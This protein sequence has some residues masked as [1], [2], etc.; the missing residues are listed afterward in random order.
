MKTTNKEIDVAL[1]REALENPVGL[2]RQMGM[3]LFEFI[4]MFWDQVSEDDFKANWHI[5]Y[6]CDELE[7]IARGVGENQPKKHDLIINIPPGT[8]KTIT[9][10]IMFPVWCWTKWPWMRFICSS[11]SGTLAMESSEKCRDII[12]SDKFKLF[13]PNMGIK[14]DKDTKSNFR[15]YTKVQHRVGKTARMH[16]GGNRYSTSVGGT[17]TG[18]HGHIL[19]VDDPLNPQQAASELELE[20]ANYWIDQTLSTRKTDKKVTPTILVMQRLHQNDPSG[21]LLNK[22]KTNVKHI[23]LPGEIRNYREHL[24]PV[25]LK[26]HYVNDLLDVNRLDWDILQELETDLGQFGYAGQIGQSPT[27][28]GGGMFKVKNFLIVDNVKSQDIVQVWR[29]WDKA[30]SEGIGAF[31]AGVKMAILRNGKFVVLNVIRGQWGTDVRERNIRTMAEA[32]GKNVKIGIEQEPG[33]SG[34]ESAQSTIRNLAGW[35]IEADRPTGNKMFRADPFS[36][37]VNNGNVLLLQGDWNKS[38]IDELRY[39]PFGTYKD[40]V[41]AASGAFS[42]LTSKKI[43][44]RIR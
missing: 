14:E 3:S 10:S 30:G 39:F 23:S 9:I 6:L 8:T 40:Q 12:R 42:K 4:E 44:R 19:I 34:K 20:K 38:F 16:Y 36:V 24:K 1:A 41:D 2:I 27:P 29:Y 22:K 7:Q 32:D 21:Y 17:L 25:E 26:Q 31:T 15:I 11:Y 33:S 37:Q 35:Y 28:P 18:F 5:P 43:A 13:Y